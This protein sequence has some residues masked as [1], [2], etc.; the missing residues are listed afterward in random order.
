MA[1]QTGHRPHCSEEPTVQTQVSI[2]YL[3]AWLAWHGWLG[4]PAGPERPDGWS[5]GPFR[6]ALCCPSA[7]LKPYNTVSLNAYLVFT[8]H[9]ENTTNSAG[10]YIGML[11]IYIKHAWHIYFITIN[12][13]LLF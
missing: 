12:Y 4:L 6:P 10:L 1:L 9:I 3:P 13:I 11:G 8:I 2:D 7:A 5:V